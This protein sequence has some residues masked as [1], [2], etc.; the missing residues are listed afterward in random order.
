MILC[1]PNAHIM[2]ILKPQMVEND[3]WLL[4][5]KTAKSHSCCTF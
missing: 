4:Y 1:E 3:N 2:I 5:H